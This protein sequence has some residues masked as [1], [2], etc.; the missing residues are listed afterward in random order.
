MLHFAFGHISFL[1]QHSKVPPLI[2]RVRR[3][4]KGGV[5]RL[6]KGGGNLGTSHVGSPQGWHVGTPPGV[7]VEN[8]ENTRTPSHVGS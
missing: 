3:L 7:Q 8:R 4:K 5:R 1:V 6:K 2:G